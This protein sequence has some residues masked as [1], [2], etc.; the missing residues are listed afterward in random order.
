MSIKIEGLKS[1]TSSSSEEEKQIETSVIKRNEKIK[2]RAGINGLEN[3]KSTEEN[4]CFSKSFFRKTN[5]VNK[6]LTRLMGNKKEKTQIAKIRNDRDFT[7]DS[8]Y[9]KGVIRE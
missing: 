7:A 1:T 3:R 5:K 4:Q 8:A 2:I 6:P 9:I